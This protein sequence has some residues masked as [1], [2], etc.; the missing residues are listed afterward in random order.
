MPTTAAETIPYPITQW[1]K[2]PLHVVRGASS[3]AA[4]G[5][6]SSKVTYSKLKGT[7]P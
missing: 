2:R 4:V 1:P 6:P 5:H 3:S 7:M